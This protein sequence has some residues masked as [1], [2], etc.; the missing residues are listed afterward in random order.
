MARVNL[1]VRHHM[2]IP[3]GSRAQQDLPQAV[4]VLLA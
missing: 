2:K 4:I 1:A 3:K